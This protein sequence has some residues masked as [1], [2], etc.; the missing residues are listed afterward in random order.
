MILVGEGRYGPCSLTCCL[1][2]LRPAFVAG[3]WQS[4]P[5]KSLG[6]RGPCPHRIKFLGRQADTIT[7]TIM[8]Q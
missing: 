4:D 7:I 3:T 8:K 1:I 2:N 5:T 6:A